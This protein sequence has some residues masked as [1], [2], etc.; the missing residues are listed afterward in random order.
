MFPCWL[1]HRMTVT[2]SIPLLSFRIS[3]ATYIINENKQTSNIFLDNNRYLCNR[4]ANLLSKH[5][6]FVF[7]ARKKIPAGLAH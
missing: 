5:L 4:L 2:L 3:L 7:A 6:T 1:S